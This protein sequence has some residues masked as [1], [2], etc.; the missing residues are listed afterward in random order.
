MSKKINNVILDSYSDFLIFNQGQAAATIFSEATDGSISHDQFTRFLNSRDYDSKDLWKFVK[1]LL[2]DI[3]AGVLAIDDFIN[4]KPFS[5]VSDI[6]CYHYSHM[7]GRC[8]KGIETISAMFAADNINIP[9]DYRIISKPIEYCDLETRR[10][11]RKS[12]ITKNDLARELIQCSLDKELDI[13]YITSDSWFCCSETLNFIAA[14]KKKY[15]FAIKSNRKVFLTEDERN[16]DSGQKLSEVELERD[17]PTPFFLN[18]VDHMIWIMKKTFTNGDGTTGTLFLVTNDGD[19]SG[20]DLYSIYHKRWGIEVFHKS[21]KNNTSLS[22]SPASKQRAQKNHIFCS[23]YAY[24]KLERIKV[25]EN[26]N[27]FHIK[28]DIQI[29]M[30]KSCREKYEDTFKLAA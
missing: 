18:H 8:L 2:K 10:V 29:L 14:K 12:L 26:K 11:K 3:G 1:P 9:V 20:D 24:L 13:S 16:K 28:R 6:N 4:E 23:F 7:K 19:L 22:K 21:V 25:T 17:V 27:H 30:L 15:I 5:K